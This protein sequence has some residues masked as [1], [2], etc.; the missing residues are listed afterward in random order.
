MTTPTEATDAAKPSGHP[1]TATLVALREDRGGLVAAL[2]PLPCTLGLNLLDADEGPII[3]QD[4]V[5][6]TRRDTPMD[7]VREGR[8]VEPSVLSRGVA[9]HLNGRILA[10]D[11]KTVVFD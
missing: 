1:T 11:D 4:V 10:Y 3:K 7:L 9:W 8:D 2:S 6:V 5:R